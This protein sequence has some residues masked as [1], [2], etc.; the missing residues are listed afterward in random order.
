[1]HQ[2]APRAGASLAGGAKC[3]EYDGARGEVEIGG[4]IDDDGV[5]AAEL[6]Q[7]ATQSRRHGLRD[8]AADG[9]RAGERQQPDARIGGQ[10]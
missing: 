10:P 6:E 9:G 4:L 1:M 2:H 8:L 7:T 3:A 5:I